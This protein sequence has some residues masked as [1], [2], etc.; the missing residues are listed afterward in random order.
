MF[1]NTL[2]QKLYP[3]KTRKILFYWSGTNYLTF[4]DALVLKVNMS[5]NLI[6]DPQQFAM[7]LDEY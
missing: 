3:M 1:K 4:Q 6:N 5:R 2:Q 7:N